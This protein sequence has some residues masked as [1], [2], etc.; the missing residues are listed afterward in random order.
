[1]LSLLAPY[2]L[3]IEIVAIVLLFVVGLALGYQYKSNACL[4]ESQA[5][6]IAGSTRATEQADALAKADNQIAGNYEKQKVATKTIYKTTERL[7]NHVVE[8][9][10][11]RDCGL[12]PCGL[13]LASAAARNAPADHC[14]CGADGTVRGDPAGT[15]KRDPG[16]TP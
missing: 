9:P 16:R 6:Y 12:D 4:A 1:M 8:K 2:R 5:Q 13:C 10:V 14:P 15:G 11:Y 3:L 7:V